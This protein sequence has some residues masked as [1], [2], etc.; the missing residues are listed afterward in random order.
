MHGLGGGGSSQVNGYTRRLIRMF[1]DQDDRLFEFFEEAE[2]LLGAET[3]E[4]CS[5]S[6]GSLFSASSAVNFFPCF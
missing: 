4:T 3:I 6:A 2:Q 1:D 5:A